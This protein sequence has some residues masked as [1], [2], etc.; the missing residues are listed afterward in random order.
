MRRIAQLGTAKGTSGRRRGGHR[1][2]KAQWEETAP[3]PPL[4]GGRSGGRRQVPEGS[5][6]SAAGL[7][8]AQPTHSL[9]AEQLMAWLKHLLP[10]ACRTPH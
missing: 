4:L 5:G 9:A 8:E 10:I 3:R 7:A 6:G 1:S 2:S